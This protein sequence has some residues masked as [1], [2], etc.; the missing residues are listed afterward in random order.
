MRVLFVVPPFTGHINPTV[1]VAHELV[2]RGHQV[3]W[4]GVPGEATQG[5][6]PDG[7]TFLSAVA[8]EVADFFAALHRGQVPN[9]EAHADH[10]ALAV[11]G[12]IVQARAKPAPSALSNFVRMAE[13]VAA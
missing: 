4:T 12:L 9:A 8:P 10:L 3:A 6:L 2:G 7:A 11:Q 13:R 1:A 5:P